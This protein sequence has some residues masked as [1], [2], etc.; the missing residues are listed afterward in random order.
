MAR[1]KI[2]ESEQVSDKYGI[3]LIHPDGD[4]GWIVGNNADVALFATE[5]EAQKHLKALKRNKNYSWKVTTE[6]RKFT[7]FKRRIQAV[8]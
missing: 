6:V 3:A 1:R 5:A 2:V 4:V 8:E 7:G